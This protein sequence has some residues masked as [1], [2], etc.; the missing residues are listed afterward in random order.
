[1]TCWRCELQDAENIAERDRHMS[2]SFPGAR[3]AGAGWRTK[4]NSYSNSD[5]KAGRTLPSFDVKLD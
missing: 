2:P 4:P 3:R 5:I 1:M